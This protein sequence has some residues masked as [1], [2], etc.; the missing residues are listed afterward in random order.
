MA[1]DSYTNIV[2][3]TE[4]SQPD[5]LVTMGWVEDFVAQ[6]T[7]MPVR[8]VSTVNL[9]GTY[10][11]APAMSLTMTA[12]GD[13]EID[14]EDV[15]V[16]DRVL[17]TAQT[18]ATHNGI[19]VC[20]VVGTSVLHTIFVRADDFNASNK[21]HSGV[22]VAVN[23]GD[24][25][26]HTFWRLTTPDPIVLDTSPLTFTAVEPPVRTASYAE[27]IDGDGTETEF[28]IEHELGT[29]DV[30]V[31]IYRTDNKS[32]VMTTVE[33]VDDDNVLVSFDIAP[34]ASQHFRVVVVG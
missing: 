33:I 16:G 4:P 28:E 26:A 6:K 30:L 21:I 1:I 2:L 3:H 24:D 25:H 13:T 11:P 17:L 7:T 10:L 23:E 12:T 32:L 18:P 9:A 34:T 27:T 29:E 14:G 31:Q 20:T 15:H 22:T 19:Y 8:L 5:H